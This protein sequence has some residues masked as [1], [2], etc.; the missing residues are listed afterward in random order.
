[1]G[2][3]DKDRHFRTEEL[4][5]D[6]RRH[7]VRAGAAAVA[8]QVSS[9]VL[10]LAATVI[11]ARILTP[12]DY[13]L[14]AMV[15]VVIG[16]A[17]MFRDLGLSQA[18]VQRESIEHKQVSTLFWINLGFGAAI[19]LVIL[20]AAPLLVRFYDE[21]RVLGITCALA[22]LSVL[23]GL[24]IQQQ[25]LLRRQL[26][27]G[28]L[29]VIENVSLVIAIGIAV[30]LAV[31]GFGFWALVG[32]EL[33]QIVLK[34]ALIWITSGWHPEATFNLRD[35]S[36]MLT[37]GGQITAARFLHHLARVFDRL[38]I[39]RFVGA[40]Q[41]GIYS[42]AYA[43]VLA[44][45]DK[46]SL[47]FSRVAIPTLSRLQSE[48]ARFAAY[49]LKALLLVA[50]AA[51]PLIAGLFVEARSAILIVLG[52]QWVGVVALIRI[53]IPVAVG[54]MMAMTTRW[55][56]ISLGRGDRLL[57][58]RLFELIFK[59]T[60]VAIGVRW[61]AQGA[62]VGLLVVS[63][64]MVGPGLA[65]CLAGSPLKLADVAATIWRPVSASIAAAAAVLFVQTAASWTTSSGLELVVIFA[66]EAAL[67]LG[68]YL[69]VWLLLPGGRA[70]LLDLLRLA[71]ELRSTR[72]SSL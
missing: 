59:V 5:R 49:Y 53:L 26:R 51:F 35:V 60:G 34:T 69:G 63:V 31:R 72:G 23:D 33:A 13:G 3:S 71:R 44:P 46:A 50:T 61:G 43:S 12:A 47:A 30:F 38:L 8:G 56:M 40:E 39:G 36:S 37:F 15:R 62:A 28:V 41:L 24:S 48:P 17:G 45:F 27:V 16:F 52:E 57:K 70:T 67:F 6:L 2:P 18:M 25:A 58:W 10:N 9:N 21:P 4:S 29:V 42:K 55:V 19:T 1:M 65:F 7:S 11:L 20:A 32:L 66:L 54:E 68:V 64:A 22:G 14:V